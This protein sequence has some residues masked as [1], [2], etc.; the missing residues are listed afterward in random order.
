MKTKIAAIGMRIQ[1]DILDDKG[2]VADRRLLNEI[3]VYEADLQNIPKLLDYLKSR[4]LTL[5]D[6]ANGDG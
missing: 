5:E 2:K 4:G 1:L 3:Q 6:K